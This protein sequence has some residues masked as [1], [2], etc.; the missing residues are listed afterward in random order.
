MS[1][2][3]E[4]CSSLGAPV[5][6]ARAQLPVVEK[7]GCSHEPMDVCL[8]PGAHCTGATCPVTRVASSEML[9]RL[10]RSGL[11]GAPDVV[12]A[13]CPECGGVTEHEL[14]ATVH[15]ICHTCGAVRRWSTVREHGTD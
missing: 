3:E 8:N 13:I 7:D 15:T 9:F 10:V 11:A 2:R 6:L 12:R 14:I 5:R 1:T 4:F